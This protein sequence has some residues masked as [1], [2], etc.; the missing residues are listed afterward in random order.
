MKEVII[1]KIRRRALSMM[2]AMLLVLSIAV[3]AYA[4]PSLPNP[5]FPEEHY[6]EMTVK[7]DIYS[8]TF[9]A[10]EI[11]MEFPHIDK[12]TYT[13]HNAVG[14]PTV[15]DVQGVLLETFLKEAF[16]REGITYN[17]NLINPGAQVMFH[18]RDGAIFRALWENLTETRY[19]FASA[20]GTPV[21]D[22][23]PVEAVIDY[24]YP[25]AASSGGRIRDESRIMFGAAYD[26]EANRTLFGGAV[27]TI[28]IGSI[29]SSWSTPKAFVNDTEAIIVNNAISVTSGDVISMRPD[30]SD[31]NTVTYFY[32]HSPSNDNTRDPNFKDPMWNSN[33]NA[34]ISNT[35]RQ[36][37]TVPQGSGTL[38]I[39][40]K[41]MYIGRP[42]S[43]SVTFTFNY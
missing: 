21:V 24:T 6:F 10:E 9:E 22:G 12:T 11:Q 32:V 27:H 38:V 43:D 30:A 4:N 31:G 35:Q 36:T 39:T 41:T 28:E 33:P 40:A 16:E 15:E 26:G 3:P 14:T 7:W 1:Q 17:R 2:I 18:T 34:A 23:I 19:S 42:G 13:S 8:V 29:V 37:V 25:S 5:Y 20:V